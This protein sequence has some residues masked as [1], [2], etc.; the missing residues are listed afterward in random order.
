M[1]GYTLVTISIGNVG[2][3]KIVCTDIHCN[4]C[5]SP[6][7]CTQCDF[8]NNYYLLLNSTCGFCDSSL[9]LFINMSDPNYPCIHCSPSNCQICSSL[10]QCSVCSTSPNNYIVNVYDDQCYLCLSVITN[11]QI[12]QTYS[13]C[14]NCLSPYVLNATDVTN[15]GQCI[16][17]P[18]IG[19]LQCIN[20]TNCLQCDSNNSYGITINQIC[21]FCNASL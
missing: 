18:L 11:C 9:N 7:I 15:T 6:S 10:T 2:C 1:N 12:C 20:I 16:V 14:Q 3:N 17:C 5:S 13:Q 21:E 4:L 8:A 19:C